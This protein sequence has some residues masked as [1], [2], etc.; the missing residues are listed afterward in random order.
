[1]AEF[2][3]EAAIRVVAELA[4]TTDEA[5]VADISSAVETLATEWGAWRGGREYPLPSHPARPSA[6]ARGAAVVGAL[7]GVRALTSRSDLAAAI[8]AAGAPL[9]HVWPDRRPGERSVASAVDKLRYQA[10][11][12][13]GFVSQARA[14]RPEL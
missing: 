11:I 14:I 12:R 1:M 5:M 13:P 10:M 8:N 2:D 3:E 9:S 7:N 4:A 6:D